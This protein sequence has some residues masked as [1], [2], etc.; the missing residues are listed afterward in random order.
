MLHF[1]FVILNIWLGSMNIHLEN[2]KV[3][4]FNFCG[5]GFCFFAF[6]LEVFGK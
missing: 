1:L 3:A 6:C 2:Y 5:A 4:A